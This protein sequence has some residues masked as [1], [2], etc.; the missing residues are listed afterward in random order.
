MNTI[1]GSYLADLSCELHHVK[2]KAKIIT[3]APTDNEGKGENF[4][5]TDL[6]AAALASC[7][8]TIIGIRA[9]KKGLD[10]KRPTFKVLKV[11]SSSPRAISEIRIEF[12][13]KSNLA[14]ADR[15]YLEKEA[16]NC[17]VA[18]SLNKDLRQNIT[19]RYT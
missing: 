15:D 18:L 17:P 5:P 14:E 11:M 8:L 13:F 10:I 19:F 1:E 4:S 2:S 16:L 3:N 12:T 6:V 7:M 9:K